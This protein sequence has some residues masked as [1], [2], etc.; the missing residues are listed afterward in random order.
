MF[1]HFYKSQLRKDHL[2]FNNFLHLQSAKPDISRTGIRAP[3][4]PQTPSRCQ[5]EMLQ[6]VKQRVTVL[7]LYLIMIAQLVVSHFYRPQT[8]FREGKV[9]TP[10]YQSFYSQGERVSLKETTL[11]TETLP[12]QRHP[13]QRRD[14]QRFPLDRDTPPRQRAPVR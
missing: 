12:G 14:G 1:V 10:V 4:A 13:E 2:V 5:L 8:K 6:L 3:L 11:H 9:F 7:R